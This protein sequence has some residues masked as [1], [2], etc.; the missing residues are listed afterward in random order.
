MANNGVVVTPKKV[1]IGL[2]EWS[3]VEIQKLKDIYSGRPM[4]EFQKTHIRKD[5]IL[6]KALHCEAISVVS[7]QKGDTA[8]LIMGRVG[9]DLIG[10][11]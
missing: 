10:M 1:T 9:L 8:V 3:T 4:V 5:L 7:V 11:L 6:Q 2:Y